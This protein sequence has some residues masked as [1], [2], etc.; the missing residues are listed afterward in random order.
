MKYFIEHQ[1][2]YSRGELLLRTFF[3]YLYIFI[4]HVFLLMFVGIA[5]W[6]IIFIS[7]WAVLFTGKYPKTFFNFVVGMLNWGVRL[8]A[9]AFQLVD[10][11][12]AF[13]L[14]PRAKNAHLEVEY[15]EQLSRGTLLLRFFFAAFYVGVP[16]AFCLWF[17]MV[18]TGVLVLLAWWAVLFTGKYPEAW[19]RFNV[20]TLRWQARINI[21]MLFLTD[22]YPPFSGKENP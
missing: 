16:H 11:Y 1:E 13:G 22:E 19:H 12:P 2:R 14:D 6:V 15:P 20:G 9:T 4:P 3:G 17:R 21:Y 8:Q 7:W 10:G 5:A 18:G